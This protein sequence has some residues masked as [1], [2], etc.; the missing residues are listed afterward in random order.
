[1]V[2]RG[3]HSYYVVLDFLQRAVGI[4]R[5]IH[6]VIDPETGE[7]HASAHQQVLRHQ[8]VAEQLF[9][10]EAT[11]YA[12][13]YYPEHFLA[14]VGQILAPR[15][16]RAL[17]QKIDTLKAVNDTGSI[18]DILRARDDVSQEL[19]KYPL[20][21]S[22]KDI[23]M[24]AG[25]VAEEDPARA[26]RYVQYVYDVQKAIERHEPDR[27]GRILAQVMPGGSALLH[28]EESNA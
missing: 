14:H 25:I 19:D 7:I 23:E 18:D 15:E 8:A 5:E 26:P 4:A 12:N 6:Q 1:R 28:P 13:L 3:Q 9:D 27:L 22:I 17:Q 24:A 21:L 16:Q 20:L 11:P 10:Q 2:N